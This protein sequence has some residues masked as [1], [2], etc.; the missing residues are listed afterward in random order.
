MTR[1]FKASWAWGFTLIELMI[2]VAIIA[3]LAMIAL[4][5]YSSYIKKAHIKAAQSDLVALGLVLENHY[6][7]NL[8]YPTSSYADTAAIKAVFSQW[9]PSENTFTYSTS[10]TNSYTLAAT[11]SGNL[12]NC[13]LTLNQANSRTATTACNIGTTW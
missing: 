4:P 8:S 5:S 11:G 9:Q 2:V 7:R 6:Q 1:T 13:V 3:I 12:L 10:T